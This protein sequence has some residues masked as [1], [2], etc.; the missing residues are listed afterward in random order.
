MRGFESAEG[1][2]TRCRSIK[3][4]VVFHA[5]GEGEKLGGHFRV[6]SGKVVRFTEIGLLVVPI[7]LQKGL[8]LQL[9]NLG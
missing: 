9:R 8:N 7:P 4:Q 3:T 6:R 1:T 2:R 5:G